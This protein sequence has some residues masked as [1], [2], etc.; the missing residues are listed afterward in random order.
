MMRYLPKIKQVA[1]VLKLT[2]S[3]ILVMFIVTGAAL[4]APG[5]AQGILNSKVNLAAT[6]AS[7]ESL[8]KKL[9]TAANVKFVFSKDIINARQEIIFAASNEKLSDVLSRLLESRNISY[10]L[11]NNQIILGVAEGA[12][13]QG[14]IVVRGKVSSDKGEALPGVSVKI[15]GTTLGITTDMDGNYSLKVP[16]AQARGTLVFTY[17]GF[18]AQEVAISGRTSINVSLKEDVKS[19]EEVVVVGYGTMKKG[20]VTGA[21]ARVGAKEIQQMPVQNALQ[22][23]QGRAAGVDVTSSN[24]PG[25]LG[26]IRIRGN[27]SLE[28]TNAPLYVV[29]GIPLMAGGIDGISPQDIESIDILKDAS[30]TAIYGSRGANGVILISTKRGKAGASQITYNGISTFDNL[31]DMADVFNSGEYAEYRRNAYRATGV[32]TT[33]YANPA[34]DKAILGTDPVAWKNIARGYTWLDEA[35]LVAQMR[36]TTAE[37]AAKW[38]VS[39]V[40]VYD[41]SLIPTTDWGSMVTRTGVTN[42]HTLSATVGSDKVTAYTSA[43]ILKQ[44]GTNKGQDY[45]RYSFKTSVDMKPATW[46]SLG[47]SINATFGKQNYGYQG[48]GSRGANG[49]YQAARGML[50]FAQPYDENGEFIY[51]PGNDINIVNPIREDQ[52]VINER[53]TWRFLGSFYSELNFGKGFKYR[54][55]FGPD[56]RNYR[57]GNFQDKNSTLRGGGAAT[58][59]HYARFQQEQRVAWTLDNLLYYDKTFDKHALNVTLLQSTTYDRQENSDMTAQNLPYTSQLWYNLQSNSDGKLQ[60]YSTGFSKRALLSYM[61]RVNYSLADKYLLTVAGRW[62]GASQL[63]AGHKWD[64]FPSLALGWKINEEE[65]M[66]D[67]KWISQL[68]ARVGYGVTGN[69][70]IDPYMTQGVLTQLPVTFYTTSMIGFIPSDPAAS[71]PARMPNQVLGWEKT[72]QVNIGVDYGFFNN[73]LRGYIDYYQSHTTD[74]IMDRAIPSVNGYTKMYYNIG[75]TKNRGID[76]TLSS[77]NINNKNFKWD[78]DLSLSYNKDRVTQTSIG[79]DMLVSGVTGNLL[80]GQPIQNYYDYKKIGIWQTADAAEMKKYNDNGEK[81]VAGD[82]RV[83]DVNGDYKISPNDDRVVIGSRFPRWTGGITNTFNYKGVELSFFLYG[84]FNFWVEG[85]AVDM[86]GRFQSRK[87]DYWTP[88]NPTNAYPRANYGNGGAPQYY[89]AMNYQKGDFI[90][91]RNVS[92]G[93]NIPSNFTRKYHVNNL[94]VYAQVLNPYLWTKNGFIDTDVNSSITSRSFVVGLNASF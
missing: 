25:Q 32:Y 48:S 75:E 77:T 30:A 14:D 9:E 33:P 72:A 38:G 82:I 2:I 50:P 34:G 39:E 78:T 13:A 90:K 74:L 27:R 57:M 20:D 66:R 92:L 94:K 80:I 83:Q 23:M 16:A 88:D 89:S 58:S 18:T 15:K 42:D 11:I 36:P 93:Y 5:K 35:N 53:T 87:V 54:M 67:I 37:E 60:G 40:P 28:A 76:F 46:F 43:N 84:R 31:V 8:L 17:L 44:T 10:E 47:A 55:N 59:T 73:R 64:F 21:T 69:S 29:D 1:S 85:G 62:D 61:A 79:A 65:F 19:L 45:T 26:D 4:A 56:F 70:A 24:R 12:A 81:Y 41:G 68:K 51:L 22:A 91:M 52:Y 63:A 86:Q 71:D 7:L 6:K 49:I 3:Q